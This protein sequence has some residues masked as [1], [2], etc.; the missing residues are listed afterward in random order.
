MSVAIYFKRYLFSY[1]YQLIRFKVKFVQSNICH[2]TLITWVCVAEVNNIYA[3]LFGISHVIC[4]FLGCFETYVEN[5]I[6]VFND[7]GLTIVP[8]WNLKLVFHRIAFENI[9]KSVTFKHQW[10]SLKKSKHINALFSI[11]F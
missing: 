4:E 11:V 6:I 10:C 3:T 5:G 9:K 7:K 1:K 2:K 8:H